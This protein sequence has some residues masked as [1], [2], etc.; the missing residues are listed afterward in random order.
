[1]QYFTK[2]PNTVEC[3]QITNIFIFKKKKIYLN[4]ASDPVQFCQGLP[5]L[6]HP[7]VHLQTGSSSENIG[8]HQTELKSLSCLGTG[9]T[10]RN[11]LKA[12]VGYIIDLFQK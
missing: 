1:M 12:N 7:L 2:Y 3:L 5:C 6:P 9:H 4:T 10:K 11:K 8:C